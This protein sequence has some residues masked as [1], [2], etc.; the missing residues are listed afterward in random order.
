MAQV[1]VRLLLSPGEDE[2]ALDLRAVIVREKALEASNGDPRYE[3]ALFFTHMT[4]LE[5]ERL[6]RFI[7]E[8]R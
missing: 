8:G 3:L 7:A 2:D 6:A 1:S 4:N 5:R